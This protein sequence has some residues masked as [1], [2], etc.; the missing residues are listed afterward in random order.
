MQRPC[1]SDGNDNPTKVYNKAYPNGRGQK[2]IG[3][4]KIIQVIAERGEY[5]SN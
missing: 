1:D 2:M 4:R 5:K 3:M